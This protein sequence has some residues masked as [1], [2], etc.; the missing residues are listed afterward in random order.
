MP[1]L[2]SVLRNLFRRGRV[3]R[4][5]DDE[6]R[7]ML[8]VLVDDHI[9]TGM[10]PVEARRAAGI[11]LGIESTK[12]QVREARRGA[13]IESVGRDVRHAIRLLWA[14]PLFTTIA[15]ASVAIGIGT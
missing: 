5:L 4:D 6:M 7:A 14:R 1:G 15:A 3:E 2:F 13:G 8:D 9:R 10:S 12:T 11:A